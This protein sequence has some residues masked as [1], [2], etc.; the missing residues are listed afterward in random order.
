MPI[1]YET[2]YQTLLKSS[3]MEELRKRFRMVPGAAE[4]AA[5][6]APPPGGG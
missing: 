2:Q 4:A 3:M 1:N 6:P 5:P